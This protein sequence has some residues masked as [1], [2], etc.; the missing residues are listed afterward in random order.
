MTD[1]D[2]DSVRVFEKHVVVA[3]RPISRLRAADDRRAQLPQELRCRVDVLAAPRA[4]AEMV[5]PDTR[6]DEGLAAVCLVAALD[7][8]RGA[9]AHPIGEVLPLKNLRQLEE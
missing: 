4:E 1:L 8:E 5:Q 2:T 9:A 7:A 3:G 6:L